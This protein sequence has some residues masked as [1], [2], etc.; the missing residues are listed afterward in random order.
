MN[1]R[2]RAALQ[3][4]A[5]LCNTMQHGATHTH[6]FFFGGAATHCNTLQHSA[7]RVTHTHQFFFGAGGDDVGAH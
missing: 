2:R 1:L 3:H 6:Q 7:T 5:I 4:T